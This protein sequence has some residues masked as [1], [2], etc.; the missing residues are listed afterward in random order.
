MAPNSSQFLVV[1]SGLAGLSFALQVADHGDVVV[2]TKAQIAEANTAYAQGGIAAAIGDEDSWQLHEHDTLVAGAGLCN[3]EAVRLLVKNG[4]AAIQWLT[5]LGAEFDLETD[6]DWSLGREGGHSRNRIL[7]KGDAT[8]MEIEQAVVNRVRAHHNIH[9]VEQAFVTQLLVRDGRCFGADV[10]IDGLGMRRYLAGATMLASGGCGMLYRNSTNPRVAT[11]DGIALALEAGA[12]VG[13]LEFMQFHPTTLYHQQ[14]RGFLI[15]E[16]ARGAGAT[17]RNHLGSRF[18]WEYDARLELAPRDIV[19]RAID[20][21]MKRL[22][23]WCVYLDLAH[24]NREKIER[25]FPTIRETL[26]RLGILL[27]RDW[28]PVV[29]AQHYS[30]GGVNTDLDART[31]IDGLY[32]AGEVANTGVHGANRLASN[33][34]LEAVVFAHTAARAALEDGSA[35]G[36]FEGEPSPP[37]CVTEGD[38]VSI[39]KHL[40]GIMTDHVG[41]VRTNAG[42]EEAEVRLA[43]LEEEYEAKTGAPFGLYS[44]ETHNL[45][46][47]GQAVVRAA[48]ARHENVGLHYNADLVF[49]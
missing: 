18:M 12:A 31:T 43:K 8:G 33:S 41:I 32:A 38:A 28:I 29:P 30:C 6:G 40:Q 48:Q 22:N 34:L 47:L 3:E 44:R 10:W 23:T 26:A 15:T 7:H 9:V 25:E 21:E 13:N 42:L 4:P 2:L 17:L 39:R 24:L 46:V 5:E 20:A 14:L 16:A 45:L 19:A 35:Q 49:A 11:G 37:P 36:T 27:H 1:G